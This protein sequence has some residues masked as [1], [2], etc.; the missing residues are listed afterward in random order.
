MP[1]RGP[2]DQF[3]VASERNGQCWLGFS[4]MGE[5][6]ERWRRDLEARRVPER[7][8]DAAPESPYGFPAEV[9][10]R[11]AT[12]ITRSGERTPTVAHAREALPPGG[13]VLDV[14]V[15]GG[16]TSLPLAV[17]TGEEPVAGSIVG[18]DGQR[19]MLDAFEAT[20]RD[21]GVDASAILGTW[22]AVEAAAPEVDVVTCGHVFYNVQDLEP[23]VR[24]LDAH[25]RHRVVVELTEHH[26]I[27][28]MNDLWDRFHGLRWPEGPTA[29]DAGAAM[30]EAGFDVRREDR[31]ASGDRGGGFERRE[32]A[33]ALVRRRLCLPADRDEEVAEALGSRLRLEDGLWSSGPAERVVVTLWWDRAQQ[34]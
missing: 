12:A 17:G 28:W 1:H 9:F 5:A 13:S 14:G 18:V 8:I 16:A 32:D 34:S 4:A 11:R 27:A 21:V 25:A 22:P 30:R 3:A 31:T 20:A 26:P 19:D 10:R 23:F 7:V 29:D 15:G 33:V 2:V 6:F 24:A